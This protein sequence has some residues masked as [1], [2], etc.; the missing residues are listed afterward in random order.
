M[1]IHW[2]PGHMH[3]ARKEMVKALPKVDLVIEV[4]D[5]RIPY[6]SENP[7]VADIRTKD[8]YT[9]PCI[10]LLNK[11]DLADEKTTQAWCD[12][13]EQ[14]RN[15]KAL[16]I[17]ATQTGQVKPLI[18]ACRQMFPD[19]QLDKPIHAMIIGIPNVG[20][21]TLI[22]SL[23][24]RMIAKT[25]NEPAVTKNQQ[26][27]DLGNGIVLHDTPG[28]LW[29]KIE[30]ENSG[31][32]LGC[33]GSIKDTALDYDDVGFYLFE[34]LFVAYPELLKA[35]YDI[36]NLPDNPLHFLEHIGARRGCL[37]AGGL[38]DLVKI[39][40]IFIN[41]LRNGTLGRISLETPAMISEEMAE[42]ERIIKEK[43]DKKATRKKNF[44]K[45]R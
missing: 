25:G 26:R 27:I 10:K 11:S 17:M 35:R 36:E 20:K 7:V 24:G 33:I 37:G 8:G 21:S 12:A 42:V 6:S 43:A 34:Y 2:Y 1:A 29:P 16:P 19:R 41:E 32:R 5:A 15:V 9:K 31:Y 45:K 30:N 28:I 14:D 44:K 22:N 4:L 18:A 38:V 23:A 40:T 39:S 3:K 13:F